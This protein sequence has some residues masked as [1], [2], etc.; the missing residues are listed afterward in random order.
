MKKIC[1]ILFGLFAGF[2]FSPF[3]ARAAAVRLV[4]SGTAVVGQPFTVNVVLD[5]QGDDANTV[6]ATVDYPTDFLSL[7]NVND[8]N[9]IINFWITPPSATSSGEVDFAGIVPGG[10]TGSAGP[11]ASLVFNP[12]VPGATTVTIATATVLRND[13]LG[14]SIPVSVSN[15]SL[16]IAT[17]ATGTPPA[18]PANSL[19]LP[20]P[21]TP[22]ITSDPN[23]FD[24]KYFLVFGTTDKGTGID[25]YEVLEVPTGE[26]QGFTP[27]WHVAQS[28]Y[29][30]QDQSLS[31][32]IYVRGVDHAG[33]F[34]VVEAAARFPS[35]IPQS[36]FVAIAV[37][38]A[39]LIVCVLLFLI[40]LARRKRGKE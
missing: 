17:P 40:W 38:R 27:A 2:V 8:G 1:I 10:F 26:M 15:L 28:P 23:I 30:L 11:L 37:L 4:A 34:I 36:M 6:Q 22:E 31:S 16:A 20:N 25:H 9:S 39:I 35:S 21:F 29:L 3:S 14:S 12:L 19:V 32:N 5:T 33:N 7:Q 13:G 18:A 24:G